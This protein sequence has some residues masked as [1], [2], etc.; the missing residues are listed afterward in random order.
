MNFEF[1]KWLGTKPYPNLARWQAVPY[2]HQWRQFSHHFPFSEPPALIEYLEDENISWDSSA[3]RVYMV[4]VSFFDFNID[5]FQMLNEQRLREIQNGTLYFALFY[6]EGDN[7]WVIREHLE[8]QARVYHIRGDQ[9]LLISAN[10]AADSLPC[11]AWFADDELLFR[12]RNRRIL[13]VQYHESARSRL[14]TALVRT[15]K[16]WR[17][18]IM[19]DFWRRGWHEFGYFS[20]NPY[21][22][23]GESEEENP[24]EIDQFPGLRSSVHDF[25]GSRF[26][27]DNLDAD[28][29]NDHHL[30]VAEHFEDS[31]INIVLETHMDVDQS[32]GV[33]LTEKTFKPIKHAQPFV[34]F[35][36]QHSL[37]RLRDLGYR[38]FQSHIDDAYDGIKNTTDRYNRL[39]EILADNFKGGREHMHNLYI[40]C[41]NDVIHNQ[42]HFLASKRD[43]LNMLLEKLACK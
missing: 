15:H 2:T 11:S 19:A 29:H 16:W 13:P 35:G 23:A 10:S 5:W 36:A 3:P 26:V 40:N 37:A 22:I 14:F 30:S 17:A 9:I 8:R 6:S 25:V 18:T 20:Y 1:D 32:G 27:A 41:K 43:R 42:R 38:T 31:Y 24:I 4:S 12:K 21:I 28:Q 39:M 34:I 7:P 33:F